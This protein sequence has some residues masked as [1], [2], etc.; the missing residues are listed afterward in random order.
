VPVAPGAGQAPADARFARL[1]GEWRRSDGDYLLH[2]RRVGTNGVAG[3]GY[4]NPAPIHV[5]V[6]T[7]ASVDGL[8]KLY[9]ELQDRGYPGSKY[10]LSLKAGDE[11]LKGTYFQAAT[12]ES[13]DVAFTRVAGPAAAGQAPE[14]VTAPA[15]PPPGR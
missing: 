4:F 15:A 14:P 13:F 12:K 11:T 1:L 7:A 5:A 10:Q 6:A 3:V 8:L 9:V 2:V